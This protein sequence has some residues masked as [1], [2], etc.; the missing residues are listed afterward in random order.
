[1]VVTGAS[2]RMEVKA[3]QGVY[4]GT[5]DAAE[6]SAAGQW[7]QG[8]IS[9]TLNIP[10]SI[11][12]RALATGGTSFQSRLT[13]QVARKIEPALRRTQKNGKSGRMQAPD[14]T[15]GLH[16]RAIL[17]LGNAT[18]IHVSPRMQIAA[19]ANGIGRRHSDP[20]V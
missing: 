20:V 11:P 8:P 16:P 2:L 3:V 17:Y 6:T 7:T 5:L 13:L 19:P 14:G 1:V 12:L 15:A 4:Q 9:L 18:K 10:F